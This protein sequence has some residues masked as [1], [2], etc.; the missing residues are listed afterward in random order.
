ML[1]E[2]HRQRDFFGEEGRLEKAFPANKAERTVCTVLP[3]TTFFFLHDAKFF[4][5]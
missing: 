3:S 1:Y 5:A 4:F 2:V